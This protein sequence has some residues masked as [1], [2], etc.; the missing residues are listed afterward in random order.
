MRTNYAGIA[1]GVK[2][3]KLVMVRVLGIYDY[4]RTGNEIKSCKYYET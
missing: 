3:L 2:S 1:L 4:E